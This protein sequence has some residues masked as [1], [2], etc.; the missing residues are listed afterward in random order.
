MQYNAN[1]LL[2]KFSQNQ[3]DSTIAVLDELYNS[4]TFR[5]TKHTNDDGETNSVLLEVNEF[6]KTAKTGEKY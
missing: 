5:F 1:W 4:T 2:K 3:I 6:L